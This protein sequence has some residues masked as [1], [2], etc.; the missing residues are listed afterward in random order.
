MRYGTGSMLSR[1]IPISLTGRAARAWIR[2]RA[3]RM[4]LRRLEPP[5][6]LGDV[7]SDAGV[8]LRP[9]VQGTRRACRAL[10]GPRVQH[11]YVLRAACE[12]AGHG[13]QEQESHG[14][15]LSGSLAPLEQEFIHCLPEARLLPAS[16]LRGQTDSTIRLRGFGTAR[17]CP[18][19]GSPVPARV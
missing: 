6:A 16:R 11:H 18:R 10:S 8:L 7:I 19:G 1:A 5:P 14:D 12:Q 4:P 13:D 2:A 9:W 17:P 3:A 15:L